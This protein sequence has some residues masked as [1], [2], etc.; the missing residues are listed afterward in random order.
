MSGHTPS[1]RRSCLGCVGAA[2]LDRRSDRHR[3]V[4]FEWMWPSWCSGPTANILHVYVYIYRYVR[5][6]VRLSMELLQC[7]CHVNPF[8]THRPPPV[9][10]LREDVAELDHMTDRRHYKQMMH[11]KLVIIREVWPI[12]GLTWVGFG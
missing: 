1:C 7:G 6:C 9:R 10:S 3:V 4:C 2:E 5:T 8:Q 11:V 12:G